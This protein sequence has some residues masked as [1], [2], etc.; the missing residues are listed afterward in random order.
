MTKIDEITNRIAALER[1]IGAGDADIVRLTSEATTADASK[2]LDLVRQIVEAREL[3]RLNRLALRTSRADLAAAQDAAERNERIARR[4]EM[5]KV[6]DA[7]EKDADALQRSLRRSGRIYQRLNEN[8]RN[9]IKLGEGAEAFDMPTFRTTHPV[10]APYVFAVHA[11][12][13]AFGL[14]PA[15]HIESW[16]KADAAEDAMERAFASLYRARDE[17]RAPE[18][19]AANTDDDA[20]GYREA[21]SQE[22]ADAV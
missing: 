17:W 9:A 20:I 1:D 12:A 13:S 21:T 16:P 3:S 6:I 19:F 11:F 10:R 22:M 7:V 2:R 5:A 15:N 4:N 8:V 14:S 18:L